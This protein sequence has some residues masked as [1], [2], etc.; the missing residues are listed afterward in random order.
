MI[1]PSR[2]FHSHLFD[3]FYR[4]Y[5]RN[6]GVSGIDREEM[7]SQLNM[8]IENGRLVLTATLT[9][10]LNREGYSTVKTVEA[11][12]SALGRLNKT[13]SSIPKLGESNI[14]K[15]KFGVSLALGTERF[16]GKLNPPLLFDAFN[17][18]VKRLEKLVG[19]IPMFPLP[20]CLREWLDGF[21]KP[22]SKVQGPVNNPTNPVPV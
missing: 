5:R 1:Y 19:V 17:S 12:N 9:E 21:A 16:E 2:L 14:S 10:T 15:D 11:I 22:T 13:R 7:E 4:H 8:S 20:E 6:A 3:A 18:G